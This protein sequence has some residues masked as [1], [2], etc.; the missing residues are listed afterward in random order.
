MERFNSNIKN[1]LKFF[2]ISGN[3]NPK[4]TSYILENGSFKP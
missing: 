3:G 2:H 4:K 1:F